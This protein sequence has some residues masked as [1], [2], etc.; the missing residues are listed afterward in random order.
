L[1]INNAT[2]YGYSVTFNYNATLNNCNLTYYTI[3]NSSKAVTV[4]LTGYSETYE[5]GFASYQAPGNL[6]VFVKSGAT[7]H[8]TGE[9]AL[10][11]T[12]VL[13][14]N[15]TW[16]YDSGADLY[17]DQNAYW[18]NLG[19]MNVINHAN[20]Y[21]RHSTF[22]AGAAGVGTMINTGTIQFS[23]GGGLYFYDN[24]GALYQCT[25]GVLKYWFSDLL[26]PAESN[27]AQVSLDGTIAVVVTGAVSTSPVQTLFSWQTSFYSSVTNF[28]KNMW[29]GN[30][31][32]SVDTS[33]VTTVSLS[34][35]LCYDNVFGSASIG[36]GGSLFGIPITSCSGTLTVF[37]RA[38]HPLA[39]VCNVFTGT[40]GYYVAQ[41]AGCPASQSL[42]PNCGQPTKLNTITSSGH[43][44]SVSVSFLLACLIA[45]LLH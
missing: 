8:M 1:T 19:F 45:M 38:N 39:P 15:G 30:V 24:L 33:A 7:V 3:L 34:E 14:N 6:T 12:V 13:V 36:P 11:G 16:I 18:I 29:I 10:I 42:N 28:P 43:M 20:D 41:P 23:A 5:S 17:F 26:Y 27:L 21:I 32:F 31:V 2:F 4:W 9:F 40:A 37:D 35:N 22:F 25:N 44:T